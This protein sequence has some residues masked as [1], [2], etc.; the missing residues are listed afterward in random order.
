MLEEA[1]MIKKNPQKNRAVGVTRDDNSVLYY[2]NDMDSVNGY[3]FSN[4]IFSLDGSEYIHRVTKSE[5]CDNIS[6]DDVVLIT[7]TITNPIIYYLKDAE[8]NT[9]FS[10]KP[11]ASKEIIGYVKSIIKVF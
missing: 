9:F 1:G 4:G 10:H 3:S 7:Q 5:S 11:D 6:T 2:D 8:G